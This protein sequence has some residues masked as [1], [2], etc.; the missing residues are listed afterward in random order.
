MKYETFNE[1][2]EQ[3]AKAWKDLVRILVIELKIGS[4]VKWGRNKRK[5]D[6]L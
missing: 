2:R 3:L 5:V 4:V 1:A 6:R